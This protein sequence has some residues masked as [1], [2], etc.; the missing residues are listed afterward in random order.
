MRV[1]HVI[2]LRH[3]GSNH[4]F[5][6]ALVCNECNDRKG[7]FTPEQLYVICLRI[8]LLAFRERLHRHYR[9]ACYRVRC[10]LYGEPS[11][12]VSPRRQLVET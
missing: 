9:R 5:N 8:L 7:G 10:W 2:P 11:G 1:D 4:Q 12:R 6:M 3:Y